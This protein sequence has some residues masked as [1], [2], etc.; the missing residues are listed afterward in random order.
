MY[1]VVRVTVIETHEYCPFYQQGDTFLIRQQ[2]FD[3]SAAT[4]KQFCMHSLN[5]IYET[6]MRMRG[7]PVGSKRIVDCCDDGIAQFELERLPDQEGPGWN[8]PP[9]THPNTHR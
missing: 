4:P 5:D 3:P 7:E 6:Y 2:C 8:R 1:S 9:T